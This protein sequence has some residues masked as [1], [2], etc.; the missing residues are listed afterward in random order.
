[1]NA[2]SVEIKK[3]TQSSIVYNIKGS[4]SWLMA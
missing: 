2:V 1:M 4:G 3:F